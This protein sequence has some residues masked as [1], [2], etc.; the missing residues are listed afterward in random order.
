MSQDVVKWLAEIQE[1]RRQLA[2]AQEE[3]SAAYA[4]AD[5]WRKLYETEAQQRRTEANLTRQT[6]DDLRSELD[7]V[8]NRPMGEAGEAGDRTAIEQEIADL[9]TLPELR[10]KLIEALME[11]DRLAQALKT[12][13]TNHTQ[14]RKSLT[15]ALG[16]TIDLLTQERNLNAQRS[17]DPPAAS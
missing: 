2:Q 17:A 6:I 7:R 8:K 15:T 3:R 9:K 12:E 4:S 1:L 14:T 5:N 16:D 10:Q 13:Q 11:C